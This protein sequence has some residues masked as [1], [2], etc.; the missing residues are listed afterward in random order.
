MSRDKGLE[1]MLSDDLVEIPGITEKTMF[2]GWAWLLNGHLLCGARNDGLL[3]RLG[4]GN[5]D[6]ALAIP[7]IAPMISRN[8]KMPGWVRVAPETCGDD[9]LRQRLLQAAQHFVLSLPAK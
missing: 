9:A 2:G 3:I 6:W 1:A 7:G 4:K 8:K 5:D